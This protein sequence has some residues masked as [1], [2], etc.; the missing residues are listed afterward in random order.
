MKTLQ[1]VLKTWCENNQLS[2]I[3][4]L[5]EKQ[6]LQDM[7]KYDF[8]ANS[9]DRYLDIEIQELLAVRQ[10]LLNGRYYT[11]VESVAKSGMSRIIK[12]K[13]ISN[14]KLHGVSDLVYTIAGCDK[15]RRISGCGMD[16]L[17]SAQYNLFVTLCPEFKYQND[18]PRYNSI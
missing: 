3:A 10:A 6:V 2:N 15:N 12:I 11:F 16:M 1:S 13:Y 4:E 8:I 17:F 14:N 18:M 7:K 5:A 9:P